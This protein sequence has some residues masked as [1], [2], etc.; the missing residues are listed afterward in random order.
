M[1][2]ILVSLIQ[3]SPCFQNNSANEQMPL[4]SQLAITLFC[5]GHFG[6]VAS[7]DAV[8]QWAGCNVGAIINSTH[9]VIRAFLLLHDQFIQWP[10]P[11]ENQ[12]SSYCVYT[13]SLHPC[14]TSAS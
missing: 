11:A 7:M 6:S 4:P 13:I 10:N 2:D 5:F 3:D 14:S 9:C 1:F 12:Q 8:A